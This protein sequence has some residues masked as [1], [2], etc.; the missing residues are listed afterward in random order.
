M[1]SQLLRLSAIAA[2]NLLIGG[3]VT[4]LSL[5]VKP[6][7]MVAYA[8]ENLFF[9]R[10]FAKRRGLPEKTVFE[11]FPQARFTDISLLNRANETWIHKVPSFTADIV[12][13]CML[14]RAIQPKL[15]FEV[16]TFNGYTTSHMALNAPEDCRVY[17]LDLPPGVDPVLRTRGT[18]SVY[19]G[20]NKQRK[21]YVW[22]D[23]PA[24]SK[25]QNLFGDS[26]TF[27]Y[28]PYYGRVDLFFIDGAH[29]Y[30]YVRSDTLNALKCCHPGSVIAWHDFGRGAI[31]GV[32]RW[33]L[34]FSK[35]H[36]VY[37]VPGSSVAFCV[38]AP[39]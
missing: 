2:R 36:R 15:V 20:L 33:L 19:I 12:S 13:L 38:I 39:K 17:T 8:N 10:T 14:C 27:N 29:S 18:D 23:T 37:A 9:F 4:S 16:G 11:I 5:L 25:I 22:E 31:N 28:S 7:E 21:R 30:E 6:R 3:N 32:S 26:G 24:A 1:T 34:E 35:Q